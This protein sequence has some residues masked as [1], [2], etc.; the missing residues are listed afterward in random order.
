MLFF[1]VHL[2]YLVRAEQHSMVVSKDN[3]NHRSMIVFREMLY[4]QKGGTPQ[5]WSPKVAL[6]PSILS[7]CCSTPCNT[8]SAWHWV[9]ENWPCFP[10][11]PSAEVPH[12]Y[13]REIKCSCCFLTT[14]R[15]G[16]Q[17]LACY[18]KLL[19]CL[20]L[21]DWNISIRKDRHLVDYS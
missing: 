21:F 13:S 14:W 19:I 11:S 3:W 6:Q 15:L 9:W 12:P 4:T 16:F 17:H 2:V 5:V 1:L 20:S 7:H 18:G 8:L 10:K